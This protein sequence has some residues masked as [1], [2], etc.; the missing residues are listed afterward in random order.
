MSSQYEYSLNVSNNLPQSYVNTDPVKSHLSK[1][2]E[3]LRL[4]GSTNI[5]ADT[6]ALNMTK[7]RSRQHFT[8]VHLSPVRVHESLIPSDVRVFDEQTS[9]EN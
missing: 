9:G 5:H 4:H 3:N 8:L 1:P 6:D 7:S 2:T